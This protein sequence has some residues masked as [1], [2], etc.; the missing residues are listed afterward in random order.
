MI[1]RLPI[2]DRFF[3]YLNDCSAVYVL[4]YIIFVIIQELILVAFDTRISNVVEYS[5]SEI[6]GDESQ[7]KCSATYIACFFPTKRFGS[8][9]MVLLLER[10]NTITI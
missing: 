4:F 5:C 7:T 8:E 3:I 6:K 10:Y 1:V 2:Y 9:S